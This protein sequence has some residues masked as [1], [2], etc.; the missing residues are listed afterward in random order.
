ME[1]KTTC[2]CNLRQQPEVHPVSLAAPPSPHFLCCSQVFPKKYD[3]T[4]LILVFNSLRGL[5]QPLKLNLTT[6]YTECYI[7]QRKQRMASA[8]AAGNASS[9]F[10]CVECP[11][12]TY[13]F[14]PEAENCSRCP[15]KAACNQYYAVPRPGSY[16]SHPRNPLVRPRAVCL[17][18]WACL[19]Q[20]CPPY[21]QFLLPGP[22]LC[23]PLCWLLRVMLRCSQGLLKAVDGS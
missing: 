4:P 14:L 15:P 22:G 21:R 5:E 12:P 3:K 2:C 13:S 8:V 23:G 20:Q 16:A 1:T 17:C 9:S 18:V 7:G 11:A 10:R 6:E 19:V